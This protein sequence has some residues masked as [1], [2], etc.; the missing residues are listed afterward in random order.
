MNIVIIGN[1]IFYVLSDLYEPDFCKLV[2]VTA[3]W[4]VMLCSISL[5][6]SEH[7][8]ATVYIDALRLEHGCGRFLCNVCNDYHCGQC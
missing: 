3:F 6:S 8:E 2:T 5:P 4:D 7:E 1:Y